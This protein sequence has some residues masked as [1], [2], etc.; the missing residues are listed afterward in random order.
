MVHAESDCCSNGNC[1]KRLLC[2]E[3]LRKLI[4]VQMIRAETDCCADTLSHPSP[5]PPALPLDNKDQ[6]P[7]IDCVVTP[8]SEWS[9]CSLTCGNG[10]K[11]RRRMIKLNPENGGK[12]CPNKLVQRRKCKDNPPCPDRM[13]DK[14]GFLDYSE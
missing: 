3:Y 7:I 10:R 6:P 5:H 8:W 14:E 12:A 9:P 11:E 13:R 2:R 4:I 1:V